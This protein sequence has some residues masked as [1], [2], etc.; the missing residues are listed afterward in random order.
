ML[1]IQKKLF[2][3]RSDIPFLPERNKIL[4]CN[5]LRCNIQDKENYI[6]HKRALKKVL[7]HGL[8]FK[9]YIK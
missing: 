7:N 3:L 8:I 1:N 2:S 5:K 4:K 9:K 6:F